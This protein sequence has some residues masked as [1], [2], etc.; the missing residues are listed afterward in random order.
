MKKVLVTG[1][2]GQVGSEIQVLSKSLSADYEFLFTDVAD[3]DITDEGKVAEWFE[4]NQ[5]SAV[6]NCAA[7]TAVDKA[8]EQKDLCY[9]INFTGAVNLAKA[10]KAKNAS[11]IHISTDYVYHNGINRPLRESDPTNP[12]SVYAASKLDGDLGVLE[13]LPSAVVLRTSWVYSSFGHNFVKTMIR[14]GKD[15]DQLTIVADQIG[16][17]TYAKDLASAIVKTL[18]A[19]Q[20]PE[21]GIYHYSNEGISSW[22]DFA[23]EIMQL[24]NID[25][26]VKP[27]PTSS[28]PTP[29][30]RPPFS[31]LDK[32][33]I[34]KALGI[35]I[36]HWK[37]SLKECLKLIKTGQ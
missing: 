20:T 32:A 7:Y 26:D 5:P 4:K 33:K 22:Y 9:R 21:G 17:P 13:A 24:E 31:V 18:V 35:S 23:Y 30:K 1:S 15:R 2:L 6:I 12:Q 19:E 28:Y 36:P 3:L 34:K 16:T 37:D 11:M 10:A 29:A 25:C 8:E 27:I 14:L